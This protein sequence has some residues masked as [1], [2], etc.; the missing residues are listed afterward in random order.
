MTRIK[1]CGIMN[2]SDLRSAILGGADALGFLVEV[3]GSRHEISAD[4]GR[5]LAQLV[6]IFAK[7][8]A[9]VAP[10]DPETAVLLAHKTGA[11]I[12]Q[13]HGT[14]DPQE[15]GALKKQIPQKIIAAVPPRSLEAS[16]MAKAADAVLLDTFKD[17]RLGG[18]G[19]VHDWSLS[20]TIAKNIEVPVILAGGLSPSNVA[21][22][23]R[24]VRPYAVDVSSGVETDGKKDQEKIASLARAVRSCQ[25]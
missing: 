10:K 4:E 11:D 17:G 5:K 20:A 9:V 7:S 8:V 13:V 3:E 25:L 23:I 1:I 14:L 16:R 12:L 6:P 24:T 15:I 21:N 2:K 22:A 18:S 19:E